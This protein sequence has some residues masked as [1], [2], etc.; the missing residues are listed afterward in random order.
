M[1][2]QI[3]VRPFSAGYK[4]I[5]GVEVYEIEDSPAIMDFELLQ[6]LEDRFGEP[7]TGKIENLHYRFKPRRSIPKFGLAVPAQNHD[8]PDTL[9]IQR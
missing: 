9:L 3:K 1:A 8:D 4:L 7:I 6:R 2:E 5:Q